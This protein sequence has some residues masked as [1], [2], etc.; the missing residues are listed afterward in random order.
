MRMSEYTD[1]L[2]KA[3][4]Q[5][6]PSEGGFERL[7]R[8]RYRK[9]RN[10][11]IGTAVAAVV[12]TLVAILGLTRAFRGDS[13]PASEPTPSRPTPNKPTPNIFSGVHG[14][15]AYAPL[16]F[17]QRI[18]MVDPA[19]PGTQV[20][21][22]TKEYQ[23]PVNW[24]S[25]GNRLLVMEGTSVHPRLYVLNQDGSETPA[26][27]PNVS[28]GAIAPDG[29]QVVY[30]AENCDLYVYDLRTRAQRLLV[31]SL[32]GDGC[33][34]PAAWSPDGSRIAFLS[35][36]G[37]SVVNADGT[38]RRVL[39]TLDLPHPHASEAFSLTWSP[40]GSR[41]A[42]ADGLKEQWRIY[43]VGSDGAGLRAVSP[44]GGIWSLTWS[45]DGSRVAFWRGGGLM[46]MAPDGTDV[47]SLRTTPYGDD[48]V[49]W[50]PG[51]ATSEIS[52]PKPSVVP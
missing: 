9:Q 7:T 15:I 14:W 4:K 44:P 41:I 20:A 25:D 24:S 23:Q 26:S 29:N 45:P 6:P 12:L 42:F 19:H 37:L 32:R 27:P 31:R 52:T 35:Q 22:P 10:Q 48:Y 16:E 39:S 40:D 18:M 21:L 17:G 3:R 49:A 38:G 13:R 30:T 46:T 11:R 33:L 8:R 47:R 43:V 34:E 36:R 50:N 28:S 5:F 51:K 2:E 1:V